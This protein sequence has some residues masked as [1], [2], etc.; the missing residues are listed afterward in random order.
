MV[1]SI[2]LAK[3]YFTDLS[4][5]EIRSVLVTKELDLF[6]DCQCVDLKNSKYLEQSVMNISSSVIV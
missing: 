2:Y 1:G 4:E 3:I 5:Y 6:K